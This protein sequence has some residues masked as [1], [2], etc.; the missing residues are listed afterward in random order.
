MERNSEVA[1]PPTYDSPTTDKQ[2]VNIRSEEIPYLNPSA[3][4][5]KRG[6]GVRRADGGKAGQGDDGKQP[7]GNGVMNFLRNPIGSTLGN[8][9]QQ[10]VRSVLPS[11]KD[12]QQPQR[13]AGGGSHSKASHKG[14]LHKDLG[15]KAGEPIP[16]KKLASAENSNSPAVRKR[17]VFAENAKHWHSGKE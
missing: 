11:G 6:G 15:V 8:Y 17:A 1:R 14:L 13:K 16:A 2:Q 7:S 5:R 12:Q 9:T 10:A 4:A 3:A